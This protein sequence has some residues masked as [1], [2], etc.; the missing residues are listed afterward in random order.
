MALGFRTFAASWR[1]SP[2][3]LIKDQP[4]PDTN[5]VPN[6][7]QHYILVSLCRSD[8]ADQ[9]IRDDVILGLSSLFLNT[10]ALNSKVT[11]LTWGH[12]TMQS[13]SFAKLPAELR[14]IICEYALIEDG[15]ITISSRYRLEGSTN[16][17]TALVR[18][19][20]QMY[21]ECGWMI[22]VLNTFQISI[23]ERSSSYEDVAQL[24]EYWLA[25]IGSHNAGSLR[26]LIVDVNEPPGMIGADK[27]EAT[28]QTNHQCST[29]RRIEAIAQSVPQCHTKVR[30]L[31]LDNILCPPDRRTAEHDCAIELD[32]HDLV[33]TA[34]L[35]RQQ[36]NELVDNESDR[37]GKLRFWWMRFFLMKIMTV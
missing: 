36:L 21:E 34:R 12:W 13:S 5:H 31:C 15:P 16:N 17:R 11:D 3:R 1:L 20:K 22:Y 23:V 33:T 27:T 35:A 37:H 29:I 14:I 6:Q 19:C 4:Y 2:D 10:G 7:A 9:D 28:L 8:N 25:A 26:K 30:L 18:T 24:L 32:A